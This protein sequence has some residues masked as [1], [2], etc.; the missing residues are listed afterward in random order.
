V[1]TAD[2]YNKGE[3]TERQE[4]MEGGREGGREGMLPPSS[5]PV[6]LVEVTPEAVA[7]VALDHQQQQQ[8]QQREYL[9]EQQMSTLEQLEQQQVLKAAIEEGSVQVMGGGT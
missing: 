3:V 1:A 4:G 7:A 9:Y 8:Q 2:A 5:H 6:V